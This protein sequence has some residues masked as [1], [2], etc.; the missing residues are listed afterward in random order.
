MQQIVL[1]DTPT[2]PC[3][4]PFLPLLPLLSDSFIA[5]LYPTVWFYLG[6]AFVG[7]LAVFVARKQFMQSRSTSG[8]ASSE[9]FSGFAARSPLAS[10]ILVSAPFIFQQPR[11][12][13]RIARHSTSP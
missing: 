1:N 7:T 8:P 12:A 10:S 13:Q 6:V 3:L 11:A 9:C 5:L 2:F 4:L